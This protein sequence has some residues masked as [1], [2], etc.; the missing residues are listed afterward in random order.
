MRSIACDSK[1][2]SVFENSQPTSPS[3]NKEEINYVTV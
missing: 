1:T 3:N 2:Q